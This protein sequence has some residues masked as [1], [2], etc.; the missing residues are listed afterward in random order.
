MRVPGGVKVRRRSPTGHVRLKGEGGI[1]G[2]TYGIFMIQQKP[3]HGIW[4]VTETLHIP[5]VEED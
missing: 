2:T 4:E 3:P 1:A 5:E